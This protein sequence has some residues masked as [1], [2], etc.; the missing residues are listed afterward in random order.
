MDTRRIH[1][2]M[3]ATDWKIP[4]GYSVGTGPNGKQYL[5]PTF[6]LSATDLALRAQ[7]L[8]GTYKVLQGSSGVSD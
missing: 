2:N 4:P 6:L 5:V 3:D 8:Q 7:E 1:D